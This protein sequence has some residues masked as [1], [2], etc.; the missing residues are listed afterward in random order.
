[1]GFHKVQEANDIQ[2]KPVV[3]LTMKELK[4]GYEDQC[5]KFVAGPPKTELE[6]PFPFSVAHIF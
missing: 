1:M 3:F 5:V 4:L 6:W 2:Q